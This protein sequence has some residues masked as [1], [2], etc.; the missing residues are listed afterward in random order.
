MAHTPGAAHYGPPAF[1][2][3][4]QA[5]VLAH[6]LGVEPSCQTICTL[7]HIVSTASV[8]LDQPEAGALLLKC[9][10]LEER[11]TMYKEDAISLGDDE[12]IAHEPFADDEFD[13]IDAMVLD[14]YNVTSMAMGAEASLF[15]Q[16]PSAHVLIDTDMLPLHMCYTP[17]LYIASSHYNMSCHISSKAYICSCSNNARCAGCKGKMADDSE[18][19]GAFW[20]LDS[21]TSHHFTSGIGDFTSYNA[22]KRAHYAK[23]ANGVV[24]IAGIGTVLLRCLDHNS[25]DEKVVTL[26]QVLHM[27]GATACLIS[28]GEMLQC[29]YRVTGDK[30][31]ISLIGKT[32][33]LWFGPDPEDDCNIIFGIRSIP[34]IRSNYIASMSKVDYDTM[35]WRFGHP[36]KEVLQCTQKHMQH[37]PEIHFPTEDCVCPAQLSFPRK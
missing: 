31:G 23:M 9:P 28:M 18:L 25:G 16:V 26:T 4:I 10:H 5:F 27:P 14:C 2:N 17:A 6:H 36:L 33:C 12:P 1:D 11:I 29:N 19:S 20:L 35:H 3:T 37:F 32:D 34:I 8:S 15:R 21:G 22:L 30:K 24:L 7:D 13:E